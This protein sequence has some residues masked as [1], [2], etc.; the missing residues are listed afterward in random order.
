MAVRY[1][2]QFKKK[3]KKQRKPKHRKA[4]RWMPTLTLLQSYRGY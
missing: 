3:K 1:K 2:G 4:E